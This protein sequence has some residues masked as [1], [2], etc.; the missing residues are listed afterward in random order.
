MSE[1]APTDDLY[2]A[3]LRFATDMSKHHGRSFPVV[4]LEQ[5]PEF[6]ARCNQR[7]IDDWQSGFAEAARR[8][9]E[10][11]RKVIDELHPTSQ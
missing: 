1:T 5:F 4:A 9:L 10:E 11:V 3:Y 8:S 7:T 2:D 6:L